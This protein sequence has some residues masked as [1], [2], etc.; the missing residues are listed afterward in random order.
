MYYGQVSNLERRIKMNVRSCILSDVAAMMVKNGMA[1]GLTCGNEVVRR[2]QARTCMDRLMPLDLMNEERALQ[3][4]VFDEEFSLAKFSESM[5]GRSKMSGV[6]LK[7]PAIMHRLDAIL[8]RVDKEWYLSGLQI[9]SATAV[10]LWFDRY[11]ESRTMDNVLTFELASM[12]KVAFVAHAFGDDLM[13]YEKILY[14]L[15]RN[16]ELGTEAVLGQWK[17]SEYDMKVYRIY[18]EASY[19]TKEI[20]LNDVNLLIQ[21]L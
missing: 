7:D 9:L 16:R 13:P 8:F 11:G 15:S 10:R 14:K 18:P 4:I 20:Y 5:L 21:N 1:V 17:E 2:S 3:L 12:E 19:Q 6:R